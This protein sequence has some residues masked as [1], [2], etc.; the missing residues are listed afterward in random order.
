MLED[1]QNVKFPICSKKAG[2][3]VDKFCCV[4]DMQDAPM[5]PSLNRTIR[6]R[7]LQLSKIVEN[8]YPEMIGKIY[9]LNPP[10][11]FYPL[12]TL[13]KPFLAESTKKQ[14]EL[15]SSSDI[16]KK[17]SGLLDD[18]MLPKEYGGSFDVDPTVKFDVFSDYLDEVSK[19]GSYVLEQGIHDKAK[20][21]FLPDDPLERA[22]TID[23]K[24][25]FIKNQEVNQSFD[26]ISLTEKH[27]FDIEEETLKIVVPYSKIM[28][29]G[30]TE[31]DSFDIEEDTSKIQVPYSKI[32]RKGL[33]NLKNS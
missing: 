20:G 2:K 31:Q 22:K 11:I 29:R 6:N 8:C 16:K 33:S 17:M 24:A 5:R 27:S 23:P 7:F 9:I 4:I 25:K 13:I 19:K 30:F 21:V 26:S 32:M 14:I 15:V 3:R 28:K 12:M 10:L 1:L 18:H